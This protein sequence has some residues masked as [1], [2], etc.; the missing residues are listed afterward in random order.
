MVV[1]LVSLVNQAILCVSDD[2]FIDTYLLIY[3]C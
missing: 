2:T 3:G 1:V